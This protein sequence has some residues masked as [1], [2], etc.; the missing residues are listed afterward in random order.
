MNGLFL[1]LLISIFSLPHICSAQQNGAEFRL[2]DFTTKHISLARLK[3]LPEDACEKV[4]YKDAEGNELEILSYS[5]AIAPKNGGDAYFEMVSGNQLTTNIKERLK[6]AK[7]NDLVVISSV[8]CIA[9]NGKK[10]LINGQSYTI[11]P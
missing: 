5:F 9:K 11:I 4:T 8:K 2:C 1:A 6:S 3:K 7:A 10:T